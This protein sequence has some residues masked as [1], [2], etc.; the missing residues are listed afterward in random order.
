VGGIV[1]HLALYMYIEER[2]CVL[3]LLQSNDLS[4]GHEWS[5]FGHRAN[6]A[7]LDSSRTGSQDVVPL[8][9]LCRAMKQH[10]VEVAM[11]SCQ[12]S[13]RFLT[14]PPLQHISQRVLES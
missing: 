5:P 13:R 11:L 3:A 4:A 10:D 2:R 7:G 6:L 14:H 9:I 1:R 12:R 8:A